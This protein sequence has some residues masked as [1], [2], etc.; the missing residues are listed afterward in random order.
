MT[1]DLAWHGSVM[2][3]PLFTDRL[4]IDKK[5]NE[6]CKDICRDRHEVQVTNKRYSGS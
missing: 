3:N 2:G 1:R 6:L 4:T 5:N